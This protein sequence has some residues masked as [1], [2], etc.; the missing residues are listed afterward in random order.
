MLYLTVWSGSRFGLKIDYAMRL[1]HFAALW[2]AILIADGK[3]VNAKKS[4]SGDQTYLRTECE[5]GP[6]G[7]ETNYLPRVRVSLGT[8]LTYVPTHTRRSSVGL[9]QARA[10]N[11]IGVK[12]VVGPQFSRIFNA[13][14]L[15]DDGPKGGTARSLSLHSRLGALCGA[16]QGTGF[17]MPRPR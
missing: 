15:K 10:N 2:L 7:D 6:A 12:V 14:E 16:G 1:R 11:Y 17:G 4:G 3:G 5:R 8:R 9:A 13:S